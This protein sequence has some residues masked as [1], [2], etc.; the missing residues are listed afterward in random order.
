MIDAAASLLQLCD[1]IE[2]HL[3][4]PVEGKHGGKTEQKNSGD[5]NARDA[6]CDMRDRAFEQDRNMIEAQQR[7]IDSTAAAIP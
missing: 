1:G 2:R 4:R 3:P 6:M 5:E 7:V